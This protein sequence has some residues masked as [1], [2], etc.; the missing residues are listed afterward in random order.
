M[1]QRWEGCT[2]IVFMNCALD[3]KPRVRTILFGILALV[4]SFRHYK[5]SFSAAEG[6]VG[7]EGQLDFWSIGVTP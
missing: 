2:R 3:S 6:K 4:I 7:I 5:T 1:R